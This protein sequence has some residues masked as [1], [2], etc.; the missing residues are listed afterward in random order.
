MLENPPIETKENIP[1]QET[2]RAA[3]FYKGNFLLMEKAGDS[4]NPGAVEFP[5]GK[6]DE[7]EGGQAS[8]DEQIAALRQ[9]VVEEAG[10]DIAGLV[11]EKVDE[12]ENYFEVETGS[13]IKSFKRKVHLYLVRLPDDI[14]ISVTYGKTLD[15]EG[16]SEDK[17]AG[18]HWV[19]EKTLKT[20]ATQLFANPY[21]NTKQRPLAR[22]SRNI[23]NLLSRINNN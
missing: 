3:L 16:Q 13:G 7:I 2:V 9:E 14:D 4:K 20:Y 11:P 22:N 5:G 1:I 17:H 19:S 6:I 21:T 18:F 8:V 12:F 23:S 15:N 10:I